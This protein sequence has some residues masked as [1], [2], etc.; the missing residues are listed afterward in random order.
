MLN[1]RVSTSEP[2]S[3]T[4]SKSYEQR[5]REVEALLTAGQPARAI[6]ALEQYLIMVPT[7]PSASHDLAVLYNASGRRPE[8]RQVLEQ[9]AA[10]HPLNPLVSRTLAEICC[11]EGDAAAALR[12]LEPLFSA[13]PPDLDAMIMA[14][15]IATRLGKPDHAAAFY[16]TVLRHSPGHPDATVRMQRLKTGGAK[17]GA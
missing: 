14:G 15:D 4:E 5:L 8:A 9:A 6:G 10:V 3:A 17:H 7:H 1:V 12:A 2:P 16:E 11:L 13:R